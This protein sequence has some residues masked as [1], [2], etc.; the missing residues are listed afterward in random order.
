M[1]LYSCYKD[2]VDGIHI[3]IS[4]DMGGQ[5]FPNKAFQNVGTKKPEEM[6]NTPIFDY[7][8]TENRSKASD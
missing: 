6:R 5:I 7:K 3:E 8:K 4:E 2:F 1:T